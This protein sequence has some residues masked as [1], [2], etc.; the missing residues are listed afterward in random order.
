MGADLV[1]ETNNFLLPNATFFFELLAFFIILWLL[2][3]Y[4]LPPVRKAID[5]R[6]EMIRKQIE[7][8][9]EAKQRLDAAEAE[10]R[11]ALL[12]TRADAARI[13]DEARAQG[14]SIVEELRVKAQEE[15]ERVAARERTRMEAERAQIVSQLRTEVGQI[16]VE[17]AGKLVGESLQDEARQRRLVER[18]VADLESEADAGDRP[19]DGTP[20]VTG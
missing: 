1:A 4:V 10:Y 2:N 9:R 5:G 11:E 12:Q 18:F 19:S 15:A 3:R 6:Q 16:A 17:L 20:A 7:E 13:R 8:S 14:Q